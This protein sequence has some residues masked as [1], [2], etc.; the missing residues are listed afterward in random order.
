MVERTDRILTRD[1]VENR[2]ELAAL[3]LRRSPNPAGSGSRGYGSSWPDYVQEAR[4]AY[5]Y[6]DARIRVI[7]S[8]REI[9]MMD[10]AIGWLR[11]IRGKGEEG[12]RRAAD[13]RRIVWMRA[14]GHRWREICRTVGLSRAQAWRRWAAALITITARLGEG[15]PRRSPAAR[16]TAQ[17]GPQAGPPAPR[18]PSEQ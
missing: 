13:D 10:E 8:A 6:H 2:L 1:E 16:A 7:P 15:K 9:Q 11:L 4:H 12:E 17:P 5:G 3:T 14:D 18:D